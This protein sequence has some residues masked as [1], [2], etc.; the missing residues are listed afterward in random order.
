MEVLVPGLPYSVEVL[1]TKALTAYTRQEACPSMFGNIVE[2]L[3]PARCTL[4][5]V[6]PGAARA[7]AV[8]PRRA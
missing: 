2:S 1:R 7:Q 5:C 6:R 4:T 8:L 3:Q